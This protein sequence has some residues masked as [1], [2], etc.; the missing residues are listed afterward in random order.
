MK[1]YSLLLLLCLNSSLFCKPTKNK[2]QPVYAKPAKK[3]SPS[4]ALGP[5][6]EGK[7]GYFFFL[8][9]NMQNIYDNG[10]IDVMA[11]GSYPIYKYLALYASVEFFDRNGFSTGSHE[12]SVVYGIPLS[13]G[14]KPFYKIKKN[15]YAYAIVGPRYSFIQVRPHS[16]FLPAEI[17]S[18]GIGFFAT[19]GL[20]LI[21]ANHFLVDVF[22][23]YSYIPVH[24]KTT[25][26]Y[27]YG[28]DVN[29]GGLTFGGGLGYVF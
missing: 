23:E 5:L 29:A 3:E 18:G 14:F 27:V 10:G 1:I 9:S 13:L 15:S 20:H 25:G 19:L 8:D 2:E 21:P 17:N 28:N 16:S 6:V 12:R 7:L 11:S 26:N 24:F 4:R 22:G